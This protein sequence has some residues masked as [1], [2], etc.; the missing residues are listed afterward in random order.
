MAYFA[1]D[2]SITLNGVK[3]SLLAAHDDLTRAVIISIFTWRRA[4]PDDVLLDGGSDRQGWWADGFAQN[5]GDEIGS[6]LWLRVR[7]KLTE[8]TLRLCKGDIEECLQWLIDDHVAIRIDVTV[9]RQGN[10]TAAFRVV[11]YRFDGSQH[12]LKF[13]KVWEQ[14]NG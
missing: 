2:F 9:E 4:G 7:E 12:E 6:K 13:S 14:L 8:D 5:A 3:T 1:Q 10:D 11:I